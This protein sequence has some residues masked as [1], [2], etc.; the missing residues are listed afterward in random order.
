MAALYH[1]EL[2]SGGAYSRKEAFRAFHN[3]FSHGVIMYFH[4]VDRADDLRAR[5]AAF[6]WECAVNGKSAACRCVDDRVFCATRTA[7]TEVDVVD[8][9]AIESILGV[10]LGA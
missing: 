9:N 3:R 6:V 8:L 1:D 10:N 2:F 5:S 7:V 4:T